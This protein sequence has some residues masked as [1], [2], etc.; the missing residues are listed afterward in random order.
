MTE[1]HI[2]VFQKTSNLGHHSYPPYTPWLADHNI[3]QH[4]FE[5]LA[6]K[7]V[8]VVN[9]Y[10]DHVCTYIMITLLSCGLCGWCC[11]LSEAS[12]ILPKITK[13]VKAFNIKYE[14]KKIRVEASLGQLVFTASTTAPTPPDILFPNTM[15]RDEESM[16][17]RLA[18]LKSLFDQTLI[19]QK[20]YETKKAEIL[21]EL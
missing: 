20:E 2:V 18:K 11:Q 12:Q 16:E 7:S 13:R 10:A 8:D 19:T 17:G 4:D 6:H 9:T 15:V 14:Q 5:E 1:Q 3:T 21:K